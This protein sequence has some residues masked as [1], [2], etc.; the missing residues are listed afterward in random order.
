MSDQSKYYELDQ[1]VVEHFMKIFNSKSFPVNVK[2][3]FIGISK[4]KELIKVKKIADDYSF[5]MNDKEILVSVNED[6]YHAMDDEI[7][8][9]LFETSIESISI[10]I[11]SGK[12]SIKKPTLQTYP[13]IVNKYGVTKV[14]RACQV[15]D[16]YEEQKED[17]LDVQ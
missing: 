4:Q 6:I 2:F 14:G 13:S 10:K 17:E 12:I 7:L 5:L 15:E 11:D 1:D 8:D 9:I 3:Q 16:L